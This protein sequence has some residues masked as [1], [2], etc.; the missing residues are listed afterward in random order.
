S[1]SPPTC[2][3]SSPGTPT[4]SATTPTCITCSSPAVTGYGCG[5]STQRRGRPSP[6]NEP[7]G[8]SHKRNGDATSPPVSPITSPARG[9]RR[10]SDHPTLRA[11]SQRAGDLGLY[12]IIL[13]HP[14]M[15][16]AVGLPCHAQRQGRPA[17]RP[18]GTRHGEHR[19][20]RPDGGG[21][22]HGSGD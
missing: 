5:T 11:V 3:A 10:V 6:V 17:R 21:C 4:L 12:R 9:I 1:R 20:I 19:S 15:L 7:V 16:T 14:R 22:V 2:R 18:E 8:T 13:S